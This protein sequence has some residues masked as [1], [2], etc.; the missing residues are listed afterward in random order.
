MSGSSPS[1][2]SAA[3]R[4]RWPR[5]SKDVAA[6]GRRRRVTARASLS[7]TWASVSGS[8]TCSVSPV[9]GL[10]VAI[11]MPRSFLNLRRRAPGQAP[12]PGGQGPTRE[13]LAPAQDREVAPAELAGRR[14]GAG[15]LPGSRTWGVCRGPAGPPHGGAARSSSTSP[16]TAA[17]TRS[18]QSS[19]ASPKTATSLYSGQLGQHRLHLGRVHVHP[20]ADDQVVATTVEEQVPVVVQA[21]HVPDREGVA[22]PRPRRGHRVSPVA[23]T[24]E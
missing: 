16:T 12:R 9:V 19:S 11:G 18:P 6:V 10:T 20:A 24:R 7:S 15:H 1:R 2:R 22:T 8:K 17:H 5:S 4:A 13:R 14:C 21:A 23:E 3:A